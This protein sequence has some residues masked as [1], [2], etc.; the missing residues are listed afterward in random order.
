MELGNKRKL[1]EY[2]NLQA[3]DVNK[4]LTQIDRNI[5]NKL[6]INIKDKIY[7]K[8]EFD[9]LKCKIILCGKKVREYEDSKQKILEELHISLDDYEEL[10]N[11]IEKIEDEN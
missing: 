10:I 9:V 4:H 3:Y 2:Y 11:H 8:Y 6:Q 7:T 5:L 1:E